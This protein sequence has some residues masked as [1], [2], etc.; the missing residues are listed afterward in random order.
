VE[1]F[2]G[3]DTAP[4]LPL[5]CYIS[6]M[7]DFSN[8]R[9]QQLRE[10]LET[11][12]AL[13][14]VYLFGS[15]ARSTATDISDIDIGILFLLAIDESR[16]FDLRLEFLSRIMAILR[17]DKV[18]LVVLNH[19]PLHLAR[20]IVAHGN[21]LLERDPRQRA[22]FEADSIERYLDFKP[23]LAVQVRAIKEHLAKEDYFD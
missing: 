2:N 22:S 9:L 16:Y 13:A 5:L 19:A 4:L 8:E 21:L 23:F 10:A 6:D 11:D 3:G 18:D 12:N 14:A 20:E 1:E 7:L 17:T 15:C